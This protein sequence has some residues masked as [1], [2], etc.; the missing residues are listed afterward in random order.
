MELSPEDKQ[1]IEAEEQYRL[2]VRQNL[3][4]SSPEKRSR[5]A[6]LQWLGCLIIVI[7]L[8][9]LVVTAVGT[10]PRSSRGAQSRQQIVSGQMSVPPKKMVMF[11]FSVTD[12][13]ANLVGRFDASGGYGNDIE[14]LLFSDEDEFRNFSNGHAASTVWS[15]GGKKSSGRCDIRLPRGEY[16][17]SFSNRASLVSTKKVAADFVVY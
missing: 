13:S 3:N 2:Q 10:R 7:V 16:I 4:S 9:A 15:S 17:L 5:L 6:P 1:R 12:S 11:R 14:V 8:G